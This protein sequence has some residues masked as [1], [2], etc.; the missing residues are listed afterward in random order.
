MHANTLPYTRL[1]T[2]SI[3]TQHPTTLHTP[4]HPSHHPISLRPPLKSMYRSQPSRLPM[5]PSTLPHC[6]ATST[7]RLPP[8]G[9]GQVTSTPRLPRH[10]QATRHP[11]LL[12][13]PRSSPTITRRR[14]AASNRLVIQRQR[15]GDLRIAR[16]QKRL[17]P[18]VRDWKMLCPKM[19]GV[20]G[21]GQRILG[22][23]VP[24]HKMPGNKMLGARL[25]PKGTNRSFSS[26]V[27]P[28]TPYS[29]SCM[30]WIRKQ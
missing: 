11:G 24:G 19:L 23:E 17:D 15:G 9:H 7:P 27:T 5:I 28:K 1:N 12:G 8:H 20:Q 21:M 13:T 22:Q 14:A 29:Q 25:S 10:G 4:R 16:A 30:R 6:R 26:H 3:P 2:P 18:K